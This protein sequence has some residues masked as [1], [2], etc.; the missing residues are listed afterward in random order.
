MGCWN[1]TCAVSQYSIRKNEKVRILFLVDNKKYSRGGECFLTGVSYSNDMYS[2]FHLSI[3]GRYDEYGGIEGEEKDLNYNLVIKYFNKKFKQDFKSLNEVISHLMES[4]NKQIGFVLIKESVYQSMLEIFPISSLP[5]IN[6]K[7][8]Q[9]KAVYRKPM[10]KNLFKDNKELRELFKKMNTQSFWFLNLDKY[11]SSNL[12]KEIYYKQLK[13]NPID[14]NQLE[15][16]K[17]DLIF[18]SLFDDLR[19]VWTPQSGAGSQQ[20]TIKLNKKF[21]K[22]MLEL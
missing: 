1:A 10:D 15:H 19:K 22:K 21:Y 2:P 5:F 8:E 11:F 3:K 7:I 12:F 18:L 13:T 9:I 16:F 17:N 6:D 14:E 20:S 4:H